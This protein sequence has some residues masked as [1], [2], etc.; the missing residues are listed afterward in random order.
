MD[1]AEELENTELCQAGL[2]LIAIGHPDL[3]ITT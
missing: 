3:F 2:V 1:D